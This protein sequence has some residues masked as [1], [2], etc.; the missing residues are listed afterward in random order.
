ML[1]SLLM[2]FGLAPAG[3]DHNPC[4]MPAW[5]ISKPIAIACDINDV[6]SQSM[7][8]KGYR[9]GQVFYRSK[10]NKNGAVLLYTTKSFGSD[11]E[12]IANL[13]GANG[14]RVAQPNKVI[15]ATGSWESDLSGFGI[16]QKHVPVGSIVTL[17]LPT[18]NK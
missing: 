17:I 4:L 12:K 1:V 9:T 11:A 15:G 7:I 3:A 5:A 18:R 2:L 6:P 13:I 14:G 10:A 8:T 16:D